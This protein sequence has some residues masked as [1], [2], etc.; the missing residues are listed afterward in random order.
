MKNRVLGSGE[1]QLL[2]KGQGARSQAQY[3]V[4]QGRGWGAAVEVSLEPRSSAKST[5]VLQV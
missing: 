4:W 2:L 5:V 1:G 3:H